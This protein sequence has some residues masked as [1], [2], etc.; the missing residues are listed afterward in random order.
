MPSPYLEQAE[1][2]WQSDRMVTQSDAAAAAR[3]LVVTARFDLEQASKTLSRKLA[4]TA[5]S[6]AEDELIEALSKI[7][8]ARMEVD[9]R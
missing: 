3:S 5:L 6:R 9:R 8:T 7:Q 2:D 4:H 1:K